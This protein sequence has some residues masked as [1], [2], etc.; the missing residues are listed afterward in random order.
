MSSI[1][2]TNTL[3]RVAVCSRSFSR[4]PLLRK[5][6]LSKFDQV[7]FNDNGVSLNGDSLI[8]FLLGADFAITAL[9]TIDDSLEME[10]S[11]VLA[12]FI[13]SEFIK[14]IGELF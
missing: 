12:S 1:R 7:K 10:A 8:E 5:T 4:H 11:A 13:L 3:D 6:I 9:E 2:I 14:L